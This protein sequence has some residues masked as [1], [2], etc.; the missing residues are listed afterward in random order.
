MFRVFP[1]R[2]IASDLIRLQR[3]PFC[4]MRPFMKL[5]T[6]VAYAKLPSL[7][8]LRGARGSRMWGSTL[9]GAEFTGD[10]V[11]PARARRPVIP[12]PNLMR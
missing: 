4:G 5:V 10:A 2:E 7:S 9:V 3:M 6:N 12:H 11:A 1:H 8:P